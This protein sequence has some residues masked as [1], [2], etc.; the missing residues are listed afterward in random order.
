LENRATYSGTKTPADRW[1]QRMHPGRLNLWILVGT[2]LFVGLVLAALMYVLNPGT[3]VSTVEP[4]DPLLDSSDAVRSDLVDHADTPVI[5][6][7]YVRKLILD[8]TRVG[9]A[10]GE[11]E[12]DGVYG[13]SVLLAA[14]S[15]A[16]TSSGSITF[17]VTENIHDDEL[18]GEIPEVWLTVDGGV[19]IAHSDSRVTKSDLHHRTTRFDFS[20]P[21][22]IRSS[23][24]ES[25]AHRLRLVVGTSPSTASSSNTLVWDLPVDLSSIEQGLA[26]GTGGLV[27]ESLAEPVE[28]LPMKSLTGV[29]RKN[30]GKV[31]YGSV[32]ES[33][34]T[35]TFATPEYFAA[36]FPS[37][38]IQTYM[39]QGQPV[40]VIS[41]STH[42][43]SLN[44]NLPGITLE[45][46]SRAYS[47][48]FTEVKVS[49]A[50]H[51]V[52]LYRFDVSEL[53][54]KS[55]ESL[56]LIMPDGKSVSW[57]LPVEY[58]V[59]NTPFG[60]GWAT[61]IALLAGMLASMWPCLFQ[62]TAYFIPALAGLNMQDAEDQVRLGQRVRVFKAA[63]YFV[64]GFTIVYTAAGALIGFAAGQLGESSFY[65][66]AQRWVA[67]G[68]GVVVIGL[69][70]RVA[71]KARAPLVCK[72]PVLSRMAHEGS[73]NAKPWE[74]MVAGLAFATGCMT[75]FGSAL[76][77]GMVVYVGMAQS[78]IY[79]AAILFLFSL[80]MGIPLVIAGVMMAKVLP[81]LFRLEKM[82]RW[83][84]IASAALML[85]FGILLISGNYMA[86]AEWIYRLTGTEATF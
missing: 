63:L 37:G 62:L 70:L 14:A 67:F 81:L 49:S 48:D 13:H 9:F 79:G 84:G 25:E 78:A 51:R 82:V 50:H 45:V 40:F 1:L 41:E 30:V 77:I 44:D 38:A 86:F 66:S 5:D 22:E 11:V 36:A 43:E 58:D 4:R 59:A 72:M 10:P 54:I 64:L 74:M 65:D 42:T 69:G 19:P 56:E 55:A 15:G 83:M 17:F 71:A 21:Q 80:G 53:E 39:P 61:I 52:T 8:L 85:S 28:I 68:A 47:V 73:G 32:N 7:R 60:I 27:D 24:F 23:S 2:V 3:P 12:I 26:S 20:L 16:K 34:I 31:S 46:G 57:D 76:V 75:C 35:A 29:L 18:I 6:D 33:E